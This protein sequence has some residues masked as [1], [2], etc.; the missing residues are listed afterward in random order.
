MTANDD[1]H[2]AGMRLAGASRAARAAAVVVALG[3][4]ALAFR[5]TASVAE[6]TGAVSPGW[7]WI[8]PLVIEAGVLTAAALAWVRSGE[9]VSAAREVA[10][11]TILLALSVVV[12]V[13]HA[14][15]G[16]ILGRVIAGVPPLVLLAA[17]EGLLREQRRNGAALRVALAARPQAGARVPSLPEPPAAA[18]AVKPAAPAEPNRAPAP[19]VEPAPDPVP[20]GEPEPAPDPQPVPAEPAVDE[21]GESEPARPAAADPA[22]QLRQLTVVQSPGTRRSARISER[23][24]EAR[25]RDAVHA[26]ETVT[27]AMIAEWLHVSQRTGSRRLKALTDKKPHLFERVRQAQ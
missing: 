26:G 13:A 22:H 18:P 15:N 12:N 21:P 20:A 3:A 11:M 23:E 27:G 17:V 2:V 1:G 4:A 14:E 24:L 16:T 10:V 25:I 7:G 9:G 5:A 8:V 19:A 6:T